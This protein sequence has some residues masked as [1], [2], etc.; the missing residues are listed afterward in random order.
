VDDD[1]SAEAGMATDCLHA[2]ATGASTHM[3]PFPCWS[4]AIFS[5]SMRQQWQV[6]PRKPLA[7]LKMM[8]RELARLMPQ[9]RFSQLV[10]NV[11]GNK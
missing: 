7:G 8:T 1:F 9:R 11:R 4:R 5:K 3:V 6:T 2:R 10:W